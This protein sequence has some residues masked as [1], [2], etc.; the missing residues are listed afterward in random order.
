MLLKYKKTNIQ[1]VVNVDR[2]TIAFFLG[3]HGLVAMGALRPEKQDHGGGS[4]DHFLLSQLLYN[5]KRNSR[6]SG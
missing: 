3:L 1:K 4:S 6:K 2:G 5:T